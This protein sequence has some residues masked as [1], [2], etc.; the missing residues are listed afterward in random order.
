M[1]YQYPIVTVPSL[2]KKLELSQPPVRAAINALEEL[3]IL[4]E[5]SGKKRD[6]VYSYRS[7]LNI[8]DEVNDTI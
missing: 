8:I 2:S 1:L 7:Y 4:R 5:V 3:G 6:K